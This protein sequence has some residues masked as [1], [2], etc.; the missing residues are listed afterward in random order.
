[1]NYDVLRERID[2]MLV[3]EVYS[4]LELQLELK[5][6]N[7]ATVHRLRS[8]VCVARGYKE[9]YLPTRETFAQLR[10]EDPEAY[11]SRTEQIERY[12]HEFHLSV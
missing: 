11:V 9:M 4:T 5:Q 7:G 6:P 12:L 3:S 10:R 8:A 1:M 2:G